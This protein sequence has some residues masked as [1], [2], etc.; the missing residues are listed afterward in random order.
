MCKPSASPGLTST[1]NRPD[2][3][4]RATSLNLSRPFA[5]SAKLPVIASLMAVTH[6]RYVDYI[7][8]DN[9]FAQGRDN[10]DVYIYHENEEGVSKGAVDGFWMTEAPRKP[11]QQ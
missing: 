2:R 1:G 9:N 11:G 6:R 7:S 3:Q 10:E 4:T 8:G 5:L